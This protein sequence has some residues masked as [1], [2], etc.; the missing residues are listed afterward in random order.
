MLIR[1][2]L[3]F[4]SVVLRLDI[5]GVPETPGS[6]FNYL[7]GRFSASPGVKIKLWILT[8]AAL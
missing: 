2:L 7:L 1:V 5:A 8:L 3:W 4:K 6:S